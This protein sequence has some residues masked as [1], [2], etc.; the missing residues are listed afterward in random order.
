MP[1]LTF[2]CLFFFLTFFLSPVFAATNYSYTNDLADVSNANGTYIDTNFGTQD[3]LVLASYTSYTRRVYMQWNLNAIPNSTINYATLWMYMNAAGGSD[4]QYIVVYNTT[5]NWTET[6]I[7]WNN[8][9]PISVLQSNTSVNGVVGWKGFNITG[10]VARAVFRGENISITIRYSNETP[11]SAA[12]YKHFYSK[13]K[14]INRP[15]LTVDYSVFD[16]ASSCGD[17]GCKAGT[18]E[19]YVPPIVGSYCAIEDGFPNSIKT[20]FNT[21]CTGTSYFACPTGTLCTQVSPVFNF[22][23]SGV[24]TRDNSTW[25]S[26]CFFFNLLTGFPPHWTNVRTNCPDKPECNCY[27]VWCSNNIYETNSSYTNNSIPEWTAGCFNPTSGLYANI[28]N[29]TAQNTTIEALTNQYCT[30][31]NLTNSTPSTCHNTTI[32]CYDVGCNPVACSVIVPTTCEGNIGGQSA[33][34]IGA[35][36]G[37]TDCGLS[38]TLIAMLVSISVG[39]ILLFYTRNDGH[40]GQAFIFGTL[41][42]LVLFTV[43]GWFY[44]WLMLILIVLGGYLVAR[45]MGLGGG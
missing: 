28:I 33:L 44:S 11:G 5:M 24:F 29:S 40:G 39:F 16:C 7:T 22:S 41:V 4:I 27:G 26:G 8:A 23:S 43:V 32:Q 31:C 30:N 3:Q 13:E 21:S 20:V 18:A 34:A 35:L 1:K 37:I 6:N 19:C 42:T 10:A 15:Y 38:Q 12:N 36:M 14:A 2:L 45:S 9:T 17:C 25:C